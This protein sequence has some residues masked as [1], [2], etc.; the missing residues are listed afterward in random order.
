[1]RKNRYRSLKLGDKKQLTQKMLFTFF[2]IAVYK[3]LS[4]VPAP[5]V[6][7]NILKDLVSDISI[8]QTAELFSGRAMTQL[9]LMATG[10]SAYITASIILQFATYASKRLDEISKSSNG[11]KMMKRITLV[12]GV[13]MS[14]FTSLVFTI[15]FSK[16]TPGILTNNSW[17]AYAIIAL[18]H[19]IGTIIAIM[20]GESIEKKGY[21]NGVSLLIA[22]NVV[23]ALPTI[24]KDLKLALETRTEVGVYVILLTILMAL[25]IITVDSSEKKVPV[26]YSKV[27]ARTNGNMR[28]SRQTLPFK[29]NAGGVMPIILASFI[30]QI[31]T[32]V[33]TLIGNE[34]AINWMTK[35]TDPTKIWYGLIT[36][37]LIVV[38]TFV[39]SKIIF[40]AGDVAENL[41]KNGGAFLGIRPG[42]DTR[43]Y[44]EKINKSLTR[45]SAVYLLIVSLIPIY[46]TMVL[47]FSGIQA[48]SL[49]I[50][51]GVS[52]DTIIKLSNEY[53]L[54]K[55]KL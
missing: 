47:K 7:Q 46:M 23:S 55:M 28:A 43:I 39:Y 14:I 24:V 51:I 45:I 6:N 54:G 13:I 22:V 38:F 15:G 17:Y 35:L 48:T 44:L 29:V 1:M 41:Q 5:F 3:L 19:A 37:I 11:E 52:L 31:V 10:V 25:I 21:G 16:Q 2:M 40:N 18:V 53:N 34:T 26:L 27:V 30:I 36:S 20:I 33:T 49:M 8:L 4:F 32:T 42:R 12:L 9:T 50:L